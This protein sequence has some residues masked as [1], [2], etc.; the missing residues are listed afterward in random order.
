[1]RITR[2]LALVLTL[3]GFVV[4]GG[5]GFVAYEMGKNAAIQEAA[6]T[7]AKLEATA[8]NEWKGAMFR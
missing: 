2:S 6:S 7:K 8:A 3:I 5:T 4:V 1:M